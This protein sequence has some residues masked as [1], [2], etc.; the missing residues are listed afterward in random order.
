MNIS[1]KTEM[2]ILLMFLVDVEWLFASLT[3]EFFFFF[4]FVCLIDSGQSLCLSSLVV[5]P[6]FQNKKMVMPSPKKRDP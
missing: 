6:C 1:F 2:T 5:G 4:G 3:M